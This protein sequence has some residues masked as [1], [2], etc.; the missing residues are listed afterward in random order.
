VGSTH[1]I[2]VNEQQPAMWSD[3]WLDGQPENIMLF[4]YCCWWKHKKFTRLVAWH[5]GRTSVFGRQTFPV[6]RST[7][8]DECPVIWVNHPLQVSHLGQLSLSSCWSR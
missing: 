8:S 2:G 5:S 6:L 7:A 1:K 3:G 4:A